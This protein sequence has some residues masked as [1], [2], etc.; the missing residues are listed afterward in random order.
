MGWCHIQCQRGDI[1]IA[2]LHADAI[3]SF[4]NE[5]KSHGFGLTKEGSFS[6][7]LRIKFD[8]N[9]EDGTITLTQKGLIKKILAATDLTDSNPNH[10]PAAT[11]ALGIDL[12][13]P[14]YT[15]SWNNASIVSML[16]YLSSNTHP[17]ISFAVSQVARFNHSPKQSHATALKMI[18]HYLKGTADKG[19][20][21]KPNGTLDL[22]TWCDA[23]FASLY[24]RDPDTDPSSVKSRGTFIIFLSNIPLFWKTQ[25]HSEITLSTTEAEYVTLSMCLHTLLPICHLLLQ[26]TQVLDLSPACFAALCCHIFQDNHAAL[27]LAVHQCITN[28]TKY[29][30]V[31]WHWFWEHVWHGPDN[32]GDPNRFLIITNESTHTMRANFFTKGLSNKKYEAN[33]AL[34]QN[35]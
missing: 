20:V 15:K 21:I 34:S 28:Q 1:G 23:D 6:E 22:D 26:V 31:K 29:F 19:M 33:H 18:V 24:K 25:L 13:G 8:K 5:L 17:D 10:H 30:L 2:A 4:V 35:W 3:D 7:Y 32:D 16:L 9:A 14:A 27:Q 12:E 11:S